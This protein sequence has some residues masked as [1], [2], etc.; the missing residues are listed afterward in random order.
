MRAFAAR[1]ARVAVGA[2]ILLFGGDG[3]TH[4][5]QAPAAE[6]RVNRDAPVTS[7]ETNF[8]KL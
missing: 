3:A 2:F 1:P 6:T 4:A 5:A 8:Q 7:R